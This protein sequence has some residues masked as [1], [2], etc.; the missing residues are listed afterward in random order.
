[1]GVIG[2]P[3]RDRAESDAVGVS[4]A[5]GRGADTTAVAGGAN[6]DLRRG[7]VDTIVATTVAGAISSDAVGEHVWDHRNHRAWDVSDAECG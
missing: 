3:W 4:S 7:S 6:R 1:M 5:A 2:P